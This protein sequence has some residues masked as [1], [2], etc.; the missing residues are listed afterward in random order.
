M[1]K[2]SQKPYKD[3]IDQNLEYLCHNQ[4]D[5]I[6]REEELKYFLM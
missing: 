4:H 5:T 1:S 2:K 6:H 3:W